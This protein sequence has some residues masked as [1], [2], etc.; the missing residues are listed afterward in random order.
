[1]LAGTPPATRELLTGLDGVIGH[2]GQDEQLSQ[3]IGSYSTFTLDTGND[4]VI[5]LNQ[6]L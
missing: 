1:M 4:S 6:G 3:I 5:A 2:V